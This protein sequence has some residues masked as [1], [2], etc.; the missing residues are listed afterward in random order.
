MDTL[1]YDLATRR[2]SAVPRLRYVDAPELLRITLTGRPLRPA[3]RWRAALST[4]R[5]ID[6]ACVVARINDCITLDSSTLTVPVDVFFAP[7]RD[8]VAN[9]PAGREMYLALYGLDE[10]DHTAEYIELRVR[11]LPA[12]DPPEGPPK[13]LPDRPGG[14][15]LTRDEIVVLI[16]EHAIGGGLT[17]IADPVIALPVEDP[18]WGYCRYLDAA[19]RQLS[20]RG[21]VCGLRRVRLEL[22]S[23]SSAVT[24]NIVLVPV[25]NGSEV[26]GASFVVAVGAAPAVAAFDLEI[27]SGTLALRR[28]T[29]DER[30]T[31]KDAG[32]SITVIVLSVIL[33]VQP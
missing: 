29:A 19:F 22:V 28:D 20:F 23:I 12:I 15:Y 32:G 30:D 14:V 16:K 18:E 17:I 6:D 24:G 13:E 9:R 8:A 4:S 27:A 5:A 10:R 26:A 7:F 25:V 33:E 11:G 31:L 2:C 3:A 1:T 21:R